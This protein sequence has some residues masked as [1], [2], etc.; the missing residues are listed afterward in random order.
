VVTREAESEDIPAAEGWGGDRAT[1]IRDGTK[2]RMA[3][4]GC[5]GESRPTVVLDQA[6][7]SLVGRSAI[8]LRCSSTPSLNFFHNTSTSLLSSFSVA[9]ILSPSSLTAWVRRF[10]AARRRSSDFFEAMEER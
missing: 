3:I 2:S 6:S 7:L 8:R 10:S 4:A 5:L 1:G 9:S